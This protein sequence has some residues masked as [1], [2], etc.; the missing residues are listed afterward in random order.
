MS[1][2]SPLTAAIVP[3]LGPVL[4]WA[5]YHYY[6][7][8]RLPEPL[9]HLLLAF[10][11]GMA[12]FWLGMLLYRALGEVGLRFDAYG[13]AETN[14]T[15]LFVYAILA[16][17]MIEEVV[18]L[19]P[20][21]LVII[22]FREFDEPIDGIIYASFIALGFAAVENYQYL[23]FLTPLE[24][25]GR[26]FAGPAVHIVFA[27]VWGFYVGCARLRGESL[28]VAS[29]ISLGATAALHGL[30]DFIVIAYPGTALPIAAGIILMLWLWR[31]RLIRALN[32]QAD[33]IAAG[34]R[35]GDAPG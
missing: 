15:G 23:S 28:L 5:G 18:K 32:T 16:I 1:I 29:L 35:A 17:G 6:K 10:I 7:D 30:Y 2:I 8:R 24:A 19:I 3:V 12:S 20:F 34:K 25:L 13:L 4:F 27:S 14:R 33:R 31:L 9:H 26:G 11:L 21:L 22:R